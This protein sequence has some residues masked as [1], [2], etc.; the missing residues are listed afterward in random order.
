MPFPQIPLPQPRNLS[1]TTLSLPAGDAGVAKTIDWMRRFAGGKEG[2]QNAQVRRVAL[3]IVRGLDPRDYS[4][5]IKN[6]FFW[7]KNNIEFRGEYRE[8]VQTPLV[9]LQLKAGDCDDHVTLIAALLMALGHR[10]RP[11]TVSTEPDPFQGQFNHVYAE[12]FDR[13][14]QRWVPID[15]TAAA[16]FPGWRPS[17]NI[18]RRQ[19]WTPMAGLPARRR[20]LGDGDPLITTGGGLT[21][22]PPAIAAPTV[23]SIPISTEIFGL[24]Q[25]ITQGIGTRIAYGDKSVNAGLNLGLQGLNPAS[26]VGLS[27]GYIL[28]GGG[29]LLLLFLAMGGRRR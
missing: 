18:Y 25:P 1:T 4:G 15:T 3:D 8:T 10:V 26:N 11:V 12:V 14:Q 21:I 20:G 7:V 22:N 23:P 16:A 27:T 17:L 6:V 19:A 13:S 5:Q 24:L 29:A 9:T 2:A 28:I